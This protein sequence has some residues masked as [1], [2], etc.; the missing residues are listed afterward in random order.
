MS[1]TALITGASVGIGYELA[2]QFA[3]GG[4]DL[5]LVARDREKL[6]IVAGEMKKLGVAAE[7]ITS[8][9]ASSAAPAELFADVTSRGRQV[10]V[11]VNNAGFGAI[12]EFH[13]VE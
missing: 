9:L 13:E 4:Y 2:R 1:R 11:L 10:D 3:R 12:G 8:D 6:E 5:I 7:V